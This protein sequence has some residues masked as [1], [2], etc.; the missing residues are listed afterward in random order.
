MVKMNFLLLVGTIILVSACGK[1]APQGPADANPTNNSAHSDTDTGANPSIEATP[2]PSA[3]PSP[4]PSSTPGPTPSV[5]AVP[6]PVTA[7]FQTVT[8]T[9]SGF[10]EGMTVTVDGV[11]CTDVTLHS[12]TEFTCVVPTG[13]QLV[14]IVVNLPAQMIFVTPFLY[15]GNLG[16][17]AGADAI[18]ATF[19]ATG[20][21]TKNLPGTWR[22]ILSSSMQSAKDRIGLIAGR[23]I[24]DAQGQVISSTADLWSLNPLLRAARYGQDGQL[25]T[26]GATWTGTHEDGTSTLKNCLDWTSEGA[27]GAI[28]DSYD[29]SYWLEV[30]PSWPCSLPAQLYC[31][32]SSN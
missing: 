3:S 14:N 22:A 4:S 23:N 19:A 6:P 7:P 32:N 11:D 1:S 25:V 10:V 17:L 2:S 24:T 29:K 15:T 12:S 26:S 27:V 9:G 18:C 31:I 20:S 21:K 16:G 8:F 5:A 13:T 30:H 28:G